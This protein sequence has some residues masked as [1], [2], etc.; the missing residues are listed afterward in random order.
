MRKIRLTAILLASALLLASCGSQPAVKETTEPTAVPV[1]KFLGDISY[2][3]DVAALV[4]E[5]ID[6][7]LDE[8]GNPLWGIQYREIT[9]IKGLLTQKDKPVL[10]YFYSSQSSDT[11]G[12]TALAED[13]AQTLSDKLL[14]VSIDAVSHN[15]IASAYEIVSLPEFV[16]IENGKFKDMFKSSEY[17]YWDAN[18]VVDW[19]SSCGYVPDTGKLE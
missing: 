13:L 15:D 7:E 3:G 9:D 10:I 2:T 6:D 4:Y 5:K 17:S 18:D 1:E 16:L 19:I 12:V 14:T 11:G 8:N